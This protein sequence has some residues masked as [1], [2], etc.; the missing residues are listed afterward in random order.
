MSSFT[1]GISETESI[2][3]LDDDVPNDIFEFHTQVASGTVVADQVRSCGYIVEKEVD[4]T[5]VIY[6][7]H[8]RF[9]IVASS[10]YLSKLDSSL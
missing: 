4:E 6:W 8:R 5:R 9:I 7:Y 1:N 3:S 10:S 2:L